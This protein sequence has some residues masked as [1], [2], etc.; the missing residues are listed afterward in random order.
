MNSGKKEKNEISF[1]FCGLGGMGIILISFILGKAAIYDDKNA[2]QTESYGAEQ[3]GTKVLS[4]LIISESEVI[5]CPIVDKADIL[6]AFSQEA[7]DFYLPTIKAGGLIFINSDLIQ[8]DEENERVYR[9]PANN[10]VMELN[11]DKV[12]N[13]I[14]LGALIKITGIVSKDS[15]IK[16]ILDTISEKNREIN[17]QAFQKGFDFF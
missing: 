3:R 6:V 17:I 5:T 8:F 16:S 2:A 4:D 7:F 14:M 1:R 15:A 9:V 12:I 10:L 13:M 11:N